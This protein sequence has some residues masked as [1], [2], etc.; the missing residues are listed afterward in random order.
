MRNGNDTE[1]DSRSSS[2]D[3]VLSTANKPLDEQLPK[4]LILLDLF[5]NKRLLY[6]VIILWTAVGV[7]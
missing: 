3:S 4:K 1:L 5:R 7:R 2:E 6:N